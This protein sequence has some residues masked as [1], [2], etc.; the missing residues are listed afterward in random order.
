MKIKKSLTVIFIVSI[1]MTIFTVFGYAAEA[2]TPLAPVVKE[3]THN[4]ITLEPIEGYEYTMILTEW[5]ESNVFTGLE[6]NRTY[7]VWQRPKGYGS[8]TSDWGYINVTTLDLPTPDAPEAPVIEDTGDGF[9]VTLTYD[10]AMEYSC[11][12]GYS[13][14]ESN[15]FSLEACSRYEFC[16][17]LKATK[18]S[19][20]SYKSS[21]VSYETS[22]LTEIPEGYVAVSTKEELNNIRYNLGGKYILTNDIVFDAADF[23]EGGMFYNDNKQWLTIGEYDDGCFTGVLEGNGYSII[24]LK[25]N[26]SWYTYRRGGL[27]GTSSG[28]IKNLHLK[29]SYYYASGGSDNYLGGICGVNKGLIYNCSFDGR[30]ERNIG[31][32]YCGGITAQ[33]RGKVAYCE[34][35]AT[36]YLKYGSGLTA[37]DEYMGGI[38]GHN[39]DKSEIDHC[40]NKGKILSRLNAE[41]VIRM[42]G[43]C[44]YNAGKIVFC[45]NENKVIADKNIEK[46][47][48]A[49]IVCRNFGSVEKCYNTAEIGGKSNNAAGIAVYNN[50]TV[51]YCYNTGKVESKYRSAGIVAKNDEKGHVKGCFNTGRII[52]VTTNSYTSATGGIVG[53]NDGAVGSSYNVGEIVAPKYYGPVVGYNDWGYTYQCRYVVDGTTGYS[54]GA[55]GIKMEELTNPEKFN[56]YFSGGWEFEYRDTPDYPYPLIKDLPFNTDAKAK[57]STEAPSEMTIKALRGKTVEVSINEGLPCD[58]IVFTS[59]DTEVAT[60][61]RN[62]VITA[63][64]PGKTKITACSVYGREA[65]EIDVTIEAIDISEAKAGDIN[66]PRYGTKIHIPELTLRYEITDYKK[67]NLVKDVDYKVSYKN[68]KKIGTA[69]ITVTGI[70]NFTGTQKIYYDIIPDNNTNPVVK[71]VTSSSVTLSWD[72][73]YGA[74]GYRILRYDSKKKDYVRVGATTD[75]SF[76]VKDLPSGTKQTFSI[77]AYKK[78]SGK[79]Y[80]SYRCRDCVCAVK[81]AKSVLTVTSGKNFAYL[82]WK[83]VTGTGYEIYM[84][85]SKDSGYKK[86]GTV[87][88]ASKTTFIKEGLKKGKTYY[89]KIKAF[90]T[91]NGE[92]VYGAYSAAKSVKIK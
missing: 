35:K 27:F 34:N 69:T 61:T 74:Q 13:W 67:M 81:P 58:N 8:S 42:G 3:V 37:N 68:H 18:E 5:Q 17:R 9:T 71:K 10:E 50:K 24:G 62:G 12:N 33:N 48:C 65:F 83:K 38:A 55:A 82:S 16:Q 51:N 46:I 70:G 88:G 31:I 20:C 30:I 54:G 15:I 73:V 66:N 52:T 91:V 39:L 22:K 43:I 26:C 76:T 84:S 25:M 86:I 64:K 60:V 75:T 45:S 89:F 2:Y 29:D 28:E 19:Y 44:G 53:L 77:V 78:V 41:N 47:Y 1:L 56:G 23:E 49:G 63:V 57:L 85:T 87:T 36:M 80:F 14:Q 90:K 11:D 92:K 40:V 6:H 59:S 7:G 79:Y 21:S 32:R 4:S 72:P